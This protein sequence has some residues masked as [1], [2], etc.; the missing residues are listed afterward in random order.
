MTSVHTDPWSETSPASDLPGLASELV[1]LQDLGAACQI[2]ITMDSFFV[3]AKVWAHTGQ[4]S[5]N[6][7]RELWA[8]GPSCGVYNQQWLLPTTHL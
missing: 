5:P 1:L 3:S 7:S 4:M 6:V 8:C 2:G